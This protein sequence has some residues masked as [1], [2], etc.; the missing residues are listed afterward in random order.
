MMYCGRI[1]HRSFLRTQVTFCRS[2]ERA[3]LLSFPSRRFYANVPSDLKYTTTHEW[4]RLEKGNT[5]G[6]IGITDHAQSSLGDIV[7]VELP[8]VGTS[9]KQGK[10]IGAVESVKAASEIYAPISGQVI[11]VNSDLK[12]DPSLLNKS[13]YEKGWIT[14][15]QVGADA[16]K[17]LDKLLDSKQYSELLAKETTH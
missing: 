17:E 6:I 3:R 15:V 2:R 16:K 4:I 11:E 12:T 10:A 9:V 14:K 5:V 7:F 1:L 13:P 8:S